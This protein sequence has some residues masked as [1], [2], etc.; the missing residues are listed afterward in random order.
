VS[1]TGKGG[2]GAG[3]GVTGGSSTGGS[4]T[5]GATTG[6]ATTGGMGGSGGSA[7]GGKGFRIKHHAA[8][9]PFI[10]G[11]DGLSHRVRVKGGGEYAGIDLWKVLS[12]KVIEKSVDVLYSTPV[13]RLLVTKGEGVTGVSASQ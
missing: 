8:A 12:R 3:G 2:T 1:G 11:A 10:R 4:D 6:G 7:T 5:G 13:T 9:F